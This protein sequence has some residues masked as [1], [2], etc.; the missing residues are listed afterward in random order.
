MTK[1]ITMSSDLIKYQL[2][3][4]VKAL[5][6]Y[7]AIHAIETSAD[8][9]ELLKVTID[10]MGALCAKLDAALR[11]LKT[12]ITDDPYRTY[13]TS[14]M[15]DEREYFT[16]L[17]H[18]KTG[19]SPF[20]LYEQDD[21]LKGV[22]IRIQQVSYVYCAKTIKKLVNAFFEKQNQDGIPISM[23]KAKAH[24]NEEIKE[25]KHDVPVLEK[26]HARYLYLDIE[27]QCLLTKSAYRADFTIKAFFNLLM[28]LVK[29]LEE[30]EAVGL[31]VTRLRDVAFKE[32]LHTHAYSVHA[33]NH[34]KA[35]S[36]Y[37]IDN[38]VEY[39]A[40]Q[41]DENNADDNPCPISPTMTAELGSR[42]EAGQS[43]KF[44]NSM[45]MFL[46]VEGNQ[47]HFIQLR[48]FAED[49]EL[50]FRALRVIG[51]IPRPALVDEYATNHP[52][53]VPPTFA[54]AFA[55]LMYDTKS[56]EG[57]ISF[58]TFT[59][60][61]ELADMAT[62]LTRDD[63]GDT[64]YSPEAYEQLF[65]GRFAPMLAVLHSSSDLFISLYL[66]A[67]KPESTFGSAI[68]DALNA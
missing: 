64:H 68:S 3:P 17:P 6:D 23:R 1:G 49:K 27:H 42:H 39:Y 58:R 25:G 26:I 61:K 67:S 7:Y 63:M 57:N 32:M 10:S 45:D 18:I 51:E 35:A 53:S 36:A 9:P 13:T 29:Q 11:K 66:E 4:L 15:V 41:L 40:K 28:N 48:D 56:K 37:I 59:G 14:A 21:E 22:M 52:E 65:L 62:M 24:I 34:E 5:K 43:M 60:V 50:N 55:D 8:D 16:F 46:E 30:I 33:M 47:T 44:N 31:D 12:P 20:M 38:I 2:D 54:G 19:H